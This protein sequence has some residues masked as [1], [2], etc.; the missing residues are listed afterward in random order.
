MHCQKNYSEIINLLLEQNTNFAIYRMPSS[1][2]VQLIVASHTYT[3]PEIQQISAYRGFVLCPFHISSQEPATIIPPQI[4]LKGWNQIGSYSTTFQR[5]VQEGR[6]VQAEY[7]IKEDSTT[8]EAYNRM[9]A[10]FQHHLKGHQ[11][12]K[13]VLSRKKV[14]PRLVHINI[15]NAFLYALERY[16]HAFVY[17][18]NTEHTGSWMGCSPELLLSQHNGVFQT[19]ALAGTQP[20]SPNVKNNSSLEWDSKNIQEQ[21]IVE[22]YMCE[23][24]QQLKLPYMRSDRYTFFA[25]NVA[26]LKTDFQTQKGESQH[27]TSGHLL[28]LIHPTPAVCGYP[29]ERA[30]ETIR[31]TEEHSRELYTGFVGTIEEDQEADLYVNLRC[32]KLTPTHYCL[33]AGGGILSSSVMEEEWWETETKM[34]LMQT[35]INPHQ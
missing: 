30:L 26:H 16:P 12:Q 8:Q 34:D 4:Y 5:S 17:L 2:E 28:S 24:F 7:H 14:V 9:F 25:G 19:T 3:E 10:S 27:V 21:A 35:I 6:D 23:L 33:F 13:L 29:K 31:A 11:V 1:S 22:E 20:I 18:A 32:L 15:A